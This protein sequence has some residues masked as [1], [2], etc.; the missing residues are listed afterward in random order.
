M[1]LA[2]FRMPL[3]LYRRGWGSILGRTFLLLVHVGRATGQPH[4]TVAM[5]LADDRGTGEVTICSGWG[6][7]GDW[8]RN[9][10]AGPAREVLVGRERFVPEHRF[11]TDDEAFAVGL[12]F[13]RRHPRRTWLISRILGWG[14]LRRDDAVRDFVHQHPF[15]ALRPTVPTRSNGTEISNRSVR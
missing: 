10:R 4:S 8:V 3:F 1:A 9:L 2:V 5:V 11:L 13:R 15:V 7:D 6:P 14:D 12:E